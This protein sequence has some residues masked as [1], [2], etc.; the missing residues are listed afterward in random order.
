MFCSCPPSPSVTHVALLPPSAAATAAAAAAAAVLRA[1][2]GRLVQQAAEEA[3]QV[4]KRRRRPRVLHVPG[5]DPVLDQRRPSARGESSVSGTW[6]CHLMKRAG[7]W[8]YPGV[9]SCGHFFSSVLGGSLALSVSPVLS[10][11]VRVVSSFVKTAHVSTAAFVSLS[12]F[13]SPRKSV[14]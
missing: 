3:G 7:G 12:L 8:R 4:D 2:F 10:E 11:V 6:S 9:S 5:A 13:P 1:F 14:Q